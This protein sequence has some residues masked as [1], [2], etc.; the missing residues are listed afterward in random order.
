M[1]KRENDSNDRIFQWNVVTMF[2]FVEHVFSIWI[3]LFSNCDYYHVIML[4]IIYFLLLM[5]D[6]VNVNQTQKHF[7][8]VCVALK[9]QLQ[10]LIYK[11]CITDSGIVPFLLVA[12]LWCKVRLKKNGIYQFLRT[13]LSFMTFYDAFFP[14][15]Y[16]L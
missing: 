16:F 13:V 10:S 7:I 1:R 8:W 5:I 11:E 15:R 2:S 9:S 3:H 12:H 14:V 6:N 4:S